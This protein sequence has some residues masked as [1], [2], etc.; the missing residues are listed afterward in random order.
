[1]EL[2]ID[3]TNDPTFA[4]LRIGAKINDTATVV[5]CTKV[6][7]REIG[8]VYATW[9]AVCVKSA[10]DYHPYAVWSIVARPEGWSAGQGDYA[11]T[12]KEAM[13]F[14]ESRGGK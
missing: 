1:M 7:N 2:V 11:F 5:A 9:V 8:E 4:E 3:N 12:L 6:C 10:D 14:Y 13:E